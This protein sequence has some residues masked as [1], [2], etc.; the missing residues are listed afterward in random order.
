MVELVE[1]PYTREECEIQFYTT[2]KM[3]TNDSV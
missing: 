3:A 2:R 1:E